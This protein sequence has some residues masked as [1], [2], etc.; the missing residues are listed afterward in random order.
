MYDKHVAALV[1]AWNEGDL[2]GLDSTVAET[3]V[4]RAPPSVNSD[5]TDLGGLKQVISDFR[6]AF[7]DAHVEIDEI[8]YQDDRSFARWTFTGTNTGPG[9]FPATGRPI[10]ITGTSFSRFADNKLT[11][12]LVHF[13]SMDMMTQLGLIELPDA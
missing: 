1:A 6:T 4:R 5:A 3:V 7:P 10:R 11:E 2:A 13:D 12:E 8:Y 9:D